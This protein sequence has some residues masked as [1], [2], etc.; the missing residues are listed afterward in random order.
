MCVLSLCLSV[1]LSNVVTS[2]R[3]MFLF[4]FF[5]LCHYSELQTTTIQ[6]HQPGTVWPNADILKVIPFDYTVHDP[7]YEDI[8]GVYS[9]ECTSGGQG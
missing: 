5:S 1:Y 2:K 7:K 4:V 3:S 6:Y 9:P 8:S